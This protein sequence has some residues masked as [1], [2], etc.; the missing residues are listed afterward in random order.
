LCP[1]QCRIGL[2]QDLMG[3]GHVQAGPAGSFSFGILGQRFPQL[4]G[5]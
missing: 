5:T 3:Y 4:H 1:L 2:S